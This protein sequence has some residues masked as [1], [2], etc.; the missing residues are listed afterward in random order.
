MSCEV[1]RMWDSF[2]SGWL[3]CPYHLREERI[4]L[5]DRAIVLRAGSQ[6]D[7]WLVFGW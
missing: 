4:C 3:M 2:V 5:R 7:D 1:L 6:Y